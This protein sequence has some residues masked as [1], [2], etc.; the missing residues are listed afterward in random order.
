MARDKIVLYMHAGS[1]NHGCEAIVNSLCHMLEHT[2]LVITNNESED[3]RYSLSEVICGEYARTGQPICELAQ[4]RHFSRHKLAHVMYYVWRKLTKDGE[5]FL[6]YRYHAVFDRPLSRYG[7]SVKGKKLAGSRQTVQ[8][9]LAVSIGG[10]NYCYEVMLKDL[11]LANRA[12]HDRG[13][14]TVL[15]GCS[16]EPRLLA[17][18]S[19][20]IRVKQIIED[21]N[22]YDMII[23]RESITYEALRKVVP[24]EKLR[25]IPDPAFTLKAKEL[26]L[27]EGFAE[28]STIGLNVSPMIQESE[29]R[30]G[31]TMGNYKALIEHIIKTTDLQVALIPHVI[32]DRNDDRRPMKELY[33]TF[34]HTG[35]VIQIED[36]SCQELKGYIAR[37][38]MFIGAR[39]HAT[40]AAYSSLVPTLVVGYSVKAKGIAKDLF[41]TSEGYVLPVQQLETAQDLIGAFEWLKDYEDDIRRDLA[42]VMP[43][44][45]NRAL[46]AGKEVE[47]LWEELNTQ[48]EI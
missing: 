37:C 10:D 39:T 47:K 42:R 41:G 48:P 7:S 12:F 16:V 25:L 19:D 45:R 8:Y 40:I 1:G 36:A 23:A 35:R 14:A 21:M 34:R 27:P 26:P 11:M 30:P 9:P 32:W 24:E 2:P 31:I 29:S 44:Y 22:L 6:R 38:R 13:T 15:L 4:E 43:A 46:Q 17:A 5:A 18:D 28:G 33:E 20:D 3:R